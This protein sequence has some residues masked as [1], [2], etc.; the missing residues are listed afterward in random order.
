MAFINHTPEV[1]GGSQQKQNSVARTRT[2]ALQASPEPLASRSRESG[3]MDGDKRSCDGRS[4]VWTL[5]P[6]STQMTCPQVTPPSS[7]TA[8]LTI[9]LTLFCALS[10]R[11]FRPRPSPAS[12]NWPN[13]NLHRL[14]DLSYHRKP[15]HWP[16][17]AHGVNLIQQYYGSVVCPVSPCDK[18][19][20]LVL[21]IFFCYDYNWLKSLL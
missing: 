19:V 6:W 9:C 17:H 3:A 8:T 20:A 16:P 15:T 4:P 10:P 18:A 1:P 14:I 5:W 7:P 21:F 11:F 2:R 13:E 12:T